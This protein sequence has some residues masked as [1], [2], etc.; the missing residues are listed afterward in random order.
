ML[1]SLRYLINGL[2]PSLS[3]WGLNGVMV[4]RT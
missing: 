2:G 4:R 1:Q 3:L